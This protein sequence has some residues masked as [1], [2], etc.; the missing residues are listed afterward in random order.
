MASMPSTPAPSSVPPG[1]IQRALQTVGIV[2]V[3]IVSIE[4]ACAT[5]TTA[6]HEARVN[7]ESGRYERVLALGVETMTLHFGGAIHPETTDREGR[8]GMALPSVYAMSATRYVHEFGVTPEQLASVSVK[9]HRHATGNPRAQHQKVVT[10]DDVLASRMI[11]DPLTLLQ[12]CSIAD[13]AAAA[14]VGP[15]RGGERDVP[16]GRAPCGRGSCGTT[17]RRDVWGW[18]IVH[19]TAGEAYEQAGVEPGDVDVFEVHDAFTI[20]EI[21][22]IEALGLAELG[23]GAKLTEYRATRRS[24]A[25][26]RSTRRAGCCRAATRW[27]PPGWPSWPRSCGSCAARPATARSTA[28]GSAWSR[29][30]AAARPASTATG[31][32]WPCWKRRAGMTAS[33][34]AEPILVDD[35]MLNA[36]RVA[37]PFPFFAGLRRARPRPLERPLPGMVPAA[38]RRR[39]GVAPRSPASRPTAFGPSTRPSST[40][41]SAA[42]AGRPSTSSSTGWCSTTRRSTPGCAGW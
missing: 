18:D 24:A 16:S 28:P 37:D 41:S 22:T 27:A 19:D 15:A 36:E 11:A 9:N 6:F 38:V 17:D 3:P 25:P 2:E 30:W 13:A 29:P 33:S 31:A 10:V 4:N 7:V 42:S 1:T 21:V 39:L 12:C 32:W 23:A 5:G 8:Q 20:G 26:S 40:T 35:D 14:V 34:E